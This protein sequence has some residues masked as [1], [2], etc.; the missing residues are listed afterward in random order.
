MGPSFQQGSELLWVS[1]VFAELSPW[2]R[3]QPFP[4][5]PS[6]PGA[7][8]IHQEWQTQWLPWH[9]GVGWV[10]DY[11]GLSDGC[12]LKQ[13][14]GRGNA[15]VCACVPVAYTEPFACLSF[16]LSGRGC[17]SGFCPSPRRLLWVPR[18]WWAEEFRERVTA[19]DS[20]SPSAVTCP[21]DFLQNYAKRSVEG[22]PQ[23]PG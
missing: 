4:Q 9:W 3:G 20:T 5:G 18:G 7:L 16:L 23:E 15:R 14:W 13:A 11:S 10:E 1:V 8:F 17:S 6:S 21:C 2:S 22:G 12:L 19:A